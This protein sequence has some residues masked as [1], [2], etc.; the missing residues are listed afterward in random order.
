[1]LGTGI[2][3]WIIGKV[4]PSF[5]QLGKGIGD[6]FTFLK[7]TIPGVS[8]SQIA[9]VFRRYEKAVQTTE[10]IQHV[11]K[12]E[13]FSK[14]NMIESDMEHGRRY[15]VKYRFTVQDN[16][17]GEISSVYRNLAEAKNRSIDEMLRRG[18]DFFEDRFQ[19]SG[20][21]I[22]GVEIANVYHKAGYSY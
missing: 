9:G 3:K 5:V 20:I 22:K 21:T 18:M 2:I 11:I 6:I 17:T 13:L 4:V 12:T 7:P 8:Q 15:M 14:A 1:M 19:D 10:K 16:K